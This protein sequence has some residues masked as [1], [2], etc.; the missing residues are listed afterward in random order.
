VEQDSTSTD[1]TIADA[2]TTPAVGEEAPD[3][4]KTPAA[5]DGTPAA[6]AD[7]TPAGSEKTPEPS[8]GAEP[9]KGPKHAKPDAD[10]DPAGA[11]GTEATKT[12]PRHAKPELNVVR[13]TADFSPKTVEKKADAADGKK[14]EA[15]PTAA[16]AA[17]S[18]GSDAGAAA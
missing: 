12:P 4:I 8:D 2:K 14:N 5:V 10:S 11:G 6:D 7:A 15:P 3:P 18:T 1:T 13:D 9:A 17:A 16:D